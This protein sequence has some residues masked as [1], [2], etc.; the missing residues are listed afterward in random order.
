[1]RKYGIAAEGGGRDEER[2][3]A[4]GGGGA[5]EAES[6]RQ[7]EGGDAQ[8][9]RTQRGIGAVNSSACPRLVRAF[10]VTP[11]PRLKIVELEK[12]LKEER[13]LR[14]GA[15]KWLQSEL[16]SKVSPPPYP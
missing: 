15:E 5:E 13:A 12:K 14:M 2:P 10:A 11:A 3:A 8:Q 4:E 7:G 1:M 6:A 9:P 16:K